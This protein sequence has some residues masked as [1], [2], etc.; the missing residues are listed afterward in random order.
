[1]KRLKSFSNA[2]SPW[3]DADLISERILP[4]NS[5]TAFEDR[6]CK[7]YTLQI[8]KE[9]ITE[10]ELKVTGLMGMEVTYTIP[11]SSFYMHTL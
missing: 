5:D 8:V 4:R 2:Y 1:M 3:E 10:V 11:R 7:S 6:V 9:T